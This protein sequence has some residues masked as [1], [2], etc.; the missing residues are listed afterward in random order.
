MIFHRSSAGGLV[1]RTGMIGTVLL[2]C[3]AP[4]PFV[5]V[6]LTFPLVQNSPLRSVHPE[7]GLRARLL[8][9]SPSNTGHEKIEELVRIRVQTNPCIRRAG[10]G[11]CVSVVIDPESHGC[12]RAQLRIQDIGYCHRIEQRG[13]TNSISGPLLGALPPTQRLGYMTNICLQ[14]VSRKGALPDT[15]NKH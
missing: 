14:Y 2:S 13:S 5:P 11:L 6:S 4:A 3:H 12:N 10:L 1:I 9:S 15:P 8:M 7:C